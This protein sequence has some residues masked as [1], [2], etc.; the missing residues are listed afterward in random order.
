MP[1]TSSTPA[2]AALPQLSWR[3]VDPSGLGFAVVVIGTAAVVGILAGIDWRM[4]I[5][6]A[7]GI[8][9][10]LAT[11]QNLL[12]GLT[13]FVF[14]SFLELVPSLTG[15]TLSLSKVAGGVLVLT[16]LATASR[17]EARRQEF[18]GAYPVLTGIMAIFLTW[19]GISVIW[20]E[21]TSQVFTPVASWLLNFALFPLIYAA[22]RKPSDMRPLIIAFVL[23]A[24]TAA[25]YGVLAQPNAAA[26]VTSPTAAQGLDRL[27]G[28]IGDPN[29]LATLLAAGIGLSAALLF[30][31]KM[32]GPWRLTI[33]FLDLLMLTAIFITLSR[34][35]LIALSAA[36]VAGVFATAS[37]HRAGAVAALA[38]VIVVGYAF[39]F[40]VASPEARDR[41]M[42]ADGGSGRTDIWKIGWRMVQDEP[43]I[44]QGA[45]NF[46]VSSIH[47]LLAPGAIKRDEFIVDQPATT[48]NSYLQVLAELGLV[49]ITLFALILI[50]CLIAAA[51]AIRLFR[52]L[53]DEE[54][55]LMAASILVA[56]AALLAGYFFLSEQYSKH[57]WLMLAFGPALLGVAR[58]E[59]DGTGHG[60]P[61]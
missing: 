16:W 20:A 31:P 32:S 52:R 15:P 59:R 4:G 19:T 29:S 13:G 56:I 42:E 50:A 26:Q 7:V 46:Q 25:V 48:H 30:N 2:R 60:N 41:V 45:G 5:A 55:A 35:G 14:L 61:A 9:L 27:A 47:Y 54:G 49:G 6:A 24:G 1:G 57:L 8:A 3:N 21:D 44:G 12:M 23:G 18:F 40:G 37:R 58:R 38:T 51:Q 17:Q 28:T 43:L 10:L 39:F 34:G 53:D 11:M 36:L 33:L 22:I